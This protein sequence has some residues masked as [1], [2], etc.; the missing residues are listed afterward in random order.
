MFVGNEVCDVYR[1]AASQVENEND[2][3]QTEETGQLIATRV[4]I[5]TTPFRPRF[6]QGN[7]D[8]TDQNTTMLIS[9]RKLRGFFPQQGDR[10]VLQSGRTL[11]VRS[12]EPSGG[13]FMNNDYVIEVTELSGPGGLNIDIR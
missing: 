13:A 11:V 1:Q 6:S 3:N 12:V 7:S 2:P 4:S 9:C 10:F 5:H 8:R